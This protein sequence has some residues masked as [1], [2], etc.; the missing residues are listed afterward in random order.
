VCIEQHIIN[1]LATELRAVSIAIVQNVK[2]T[3]EHAYEKYELI[4]T[5]T[6]KREAVSPLK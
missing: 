2:Y 3:V 4:I 6:Y 5:K 1:V